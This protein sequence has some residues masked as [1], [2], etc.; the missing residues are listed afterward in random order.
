MWCWVACAQMM[1]LDYFPRMEKSQSWA[2][3]RVWQ[4]AMDG[5]GT[6]A[7][8]AEA[9]NHFISSV[10]DISYDIQASP[11]KTILTEE[12]LTNYLDAG[13]TV[14]IRRVHCNSDGSSPIGHT[15][16]VTE[17]EQ[18]SGENYFFIWD[19]EPEDEGSTLGMTY[20]Q[21]CREELTDGYMCWESFV[22]QNNLFFDDTT[23]VV[24]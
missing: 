3:G 10:T 8:T 23:S 4:I 1:A 11:A 13:H 18:I 12:G 17:Y 16:L 2:V 21:I 24:L 20:E 15:T 5:A 14:I 7:E 19:S 22:A 6:L 9:A